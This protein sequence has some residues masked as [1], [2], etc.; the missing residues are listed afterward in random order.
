MLLHHM[1]NKKFDSFNTS[2]QMVTLLHYLD[3][4]HCSILSLSKKT[5][6]DHVL[7]ILH[8]ILMTETTKERYHNQLDIINPLFEQTKVVVIGA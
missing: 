7:Y 6:L 8:D 2:D 5:D 3:R 1:D 4:D